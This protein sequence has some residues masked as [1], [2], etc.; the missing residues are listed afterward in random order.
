MVSVMEIGDVF[1]LLTVEKY[2]GVDK[3]SNR[4]YL[5]KCECGNF[6]EVRGTY[7]KSGH[8]TSCGCKR[9]KAYRD[10]KNRKSGSVY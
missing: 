9:R 6:V 5:C 2:V 7:L 4:M 10:R 3:H 8:T 1:G